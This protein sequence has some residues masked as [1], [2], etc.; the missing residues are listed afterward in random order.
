MKHERPGIELSGQPLGFAEMVRI[1]S[2]KVALSASA[3]GMARIQHAR[4]IVE[5]AINSGVPE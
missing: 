4:L 2:G 1:G 5:E 3:A